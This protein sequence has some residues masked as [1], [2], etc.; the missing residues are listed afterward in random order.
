MER[1]GFSPTPTKSS[2]GDTQHETDAFE[3]LGSPVVMTPINQVSPVSDIQEDPQPLVNVAENQPSGI[4]RWLADK[5]D[6]SSMKPE[7]RHR[8]SHV[9]VEQ[10]AEA[11]SVS[12]FLG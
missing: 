1:S 9:P 11:G 3:E 4:T 12:R 6:H 7:D 8:N 5:A 10:E 2:P